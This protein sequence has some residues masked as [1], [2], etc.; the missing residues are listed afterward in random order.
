MSGSASLSGTGLGKQTSSL[1]ARSTDASKPT[2]N[3]ALGNFHGTSVTL[4]SPWRFKPAGVHEVQ[5]RFD[6]VLKET[7][8]QGRL[9][10]LNENHVFLLYSEDKDHLDIL[11]QHLDR[12]TRQIHQEAGA[13]GARMDD[14]TTDE[15]S[16]SDDSEDL[17]FRSHLI[18]KVSDRVIRKD[19]LSKQ[20]AHDPFYPPEFAAFD[21][22]SFWS[23]RG[24]WLDEILSARDVSSLMDST[25]SMIKVAVAEGKVYIG[26]DNAASVE[27]AKSKLEVIVKHKERHHTKLFHHIFYTENFDKCRFVVRVA[28]SIKKYH[29]ETI[30]MES[31]QLY[32]L[33]EN[34][35]IVRACP[36]EV[37]KSDYIMFQMGK[38][39][40]AV[41][42]S[43]TVGSTASS[44]SWASF[45]FKPRG[46][47]NPENHFS[48]GYN[49]ALKRQEEEE[50]AEEQAALAARGALPKPGET[51][52]TAIEE[53]AGTVSKEAAQESSS[54]IRP[55]LTSS[56]ARLDLA[57]PEISTTSSV[58]Q[59]QS[60][61]QPARPKSSGQSSSITNT[62]EASAQTQSA[63]E[64]REQA[65]LKHSPA[66]NDRL[67]A[68]KNENLR[69][70]TLDTHTSAWGFPVVPIREQAPLK[71]SAAPSYRLEATNEELLRAPTFDTN[72]SPWG[73]PVAPIREEANHLRHVREVDE[74]VL[75]NFGNTSTSTSVWPVVDAPPTSSHP[76]FF[77]L[78]STSGS[79]LS[80]R[81]PHPPSEDILL[82]FPVLT[83]SE[84]SNALPTPR[85]RETD[86]ARSKTFHQTMRQRASR[87]P[88]F[89]RSTVDPQPGFLRKVEAQLSR[90][91]TPVRGY[92]GQVTVQLDFGRILLGNLPKKL[93][94]TGTHDTKLEEENITNYFLPP[95]DVRPGDGPE[96]HFTKI[97]SLV[98]ADTTF[99]RNLRSKEG[100]RLWL[101]DVAEW[102][103]VYEFECQHL[104]SRVVFAIE[105]DSE[106]FE[107]KIKVRK[108]F[109]DIYV[110]GTMRN[111]DC[112]ISA[113]GYSNEN[114]IPDD[115]QIYSELADVI[116]KSL[117][118]PP[119]QNKP[120]HAIQ[121]PDYLFPFVEIYSL[122]IR[123]TKSYLSQDRQ[124]KL[125]I[126]E[127]DKSCGDM[128]KVKDK[129][130]NVYIYREEKKEQTDE[131]TNWFEVSLTS[132]MM[133]EFLKENTQLQLGQ[134]TKWRLK[135]L[136]TNKVSDSLIRP[137]C[138]MLTQMDG[139]GFYNNNGLR[140]KGKGISRQESSGPETPVPRVPIRDPVSGIEW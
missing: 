123:K 132:V 75:I 120:N 90:L 3:R 28:S 57:P 20:D 138:A 71:H 46:T 131:E 105:V 76:D 84:P 80:P 136:I 91:M 51:T 95:A 137:A 35:V 135:D 61:S 119:D 22:R 103:V 65:S 127:V 110:H 77:S 32:G 1:N 98:E 115:W 17:E 56:L 109:G 99:L 49:A 60:V 106:T 107:T 12:I 40:P 23:W 34:G 69:E 92:C 21:H 64:S 42:Q 67:G 11:Y 112:R 108:D 53:W 54:K 63:V 52:V 58:P 30:L 125:H 124:S 15:D 89:P 85:I 18:E 73:F 101:K 86:E 129:N 24:L 93:V 81:R 13:D 6:A 128:L 19:E 102:K 37:M 83:P 45:V 134:E 88:I 139:V 62:Q 117:F 36:V 113:V 100:G 4:G 74:D 116:K 66:P 41:P 47:D 140:K 118:I 122:R 121:V 111:W 78:G 7:G 114:E 82:D 50:I 72:A 48:D 16:D 96:L 2:N 26:A 133:D 25:D 14:Y 43:Q 8:T 9:R 68:P 87:P 5:R 39:V 94:S 70:P 29:I 44:K 130:I 27:D 104:E 55:P 38:H 31:K 10:W 126:T 33:V 79:E 59:K 97:V